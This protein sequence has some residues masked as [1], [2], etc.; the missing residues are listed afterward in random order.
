[1]ATVNHA[2]KLEYIKQHLLGDL[3]PIGLSISD[4]NEWSSQ[5]ST[6]FSTS[7][8]D[9]LCSQTSSSDSIIQEAYYVNPSEFIEFS[10]DFFDF[11]LNPELIDLITTP[12]SQAL[13]SQS[14]DNSFEFESKPQI[15]DLGVATSQSNSFSFEFESKPQIHR[16][17]NRKPALTISLPVKTEWIQFEDPKPQVSVQ[18]KSIEVEK[19]HYRG[20]RRRPWG[21]FASE[22][23]DPNKGW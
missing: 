22:I 21:K 1:M 9:S 18:E 8:S 10:S 4:Q 20:V 17:T 15:F 3:S 12:K 16:Q 23:R 7:L 14:S 13:T 19:R 6:H 2:S 11:E 5:V